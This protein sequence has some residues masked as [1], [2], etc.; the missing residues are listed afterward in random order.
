MGS[1]A[2]ALGQAVPAAPS[3][4]RLL[5]L[6]SEKPESW[7]P[8]GSA[9]LDRRASCLAEPTPREA[10][11][12]SDRK[13]TESNRPALI[14]ATW[15][16][17]RKQEDQHWGT[18]GPLALGQQEPAQHP[19]PSTCMWDAWW[20]RHFTPRISGGGCRP[21]SWCAPGREPASGPLVP[22]SQVCRHLLPCGCP[23][24]S[25]HQRIGWAVATGK[26]GAG[27]GRS[28]PGS[29]E[30][31]CPKPGP[32]VVY[33]L[34]VQRE[35]TRGCVLWQEG[36]E[37]SGLAG[38][39]GKGKQA[40]NSSVDQA[41]GASSSS[42]GEVTALTGTSVSAVMPGRARGGGTGQGDG[43]PGT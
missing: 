36:R 2:Q 17:E 11:A 3:V 5:T 22:P 16:T 4:T 30:T 25:G 33:D 41:Q 13:W 40:I 32:A 43:T 8:L 1:L 12:Y 7:G 28:L 39:Q 23:T 10:S 26:A 42:S 24:G 29:Y 19:A 37:P 38:A 27:S 31:R 6:D 14:A 35:R 20:C 21:R 34:S 18:R 9:S 15:G